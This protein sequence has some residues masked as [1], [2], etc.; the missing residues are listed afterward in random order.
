MKTQILRTV[1][2]A[3]ALI[4]LLFAVSCDTVVDLDQENSAENDLP[5]NETETKESDNLEITMNLYNKN[6]TLRYHANE[7]GISKVVIDGKVY[8]NNTSNRYRKTGVIIPKEDIL[9]NAIIDIYC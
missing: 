8:E 3:L 7:E 4:M 1:C 2:G 6:V 5:E 9:D